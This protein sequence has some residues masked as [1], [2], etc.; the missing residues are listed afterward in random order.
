MNRNF[1]L[2]VLRAL[3][4]IFVLLSHSRFFLV[5]AIPEARYLQLGG[6]WGVELFFVLSGLLIGRIIVKEVI[7]EETFSLITFWK[8]RWY[9]TIPNYSLFL[10]LNILYLLTVS[11]SAAPI[12]KYFLFMQNFAWEHPLFFP[13]SWSL[14]VEEMFY[15]IFPILVVVL[16]R[17][18][19]KSERAF[20]MAGISILFL[21]TTFRFLHVYFT[22]PNWND[23]VRTIVIYRLDAL[24]YGILSALYLH[25]KKTIRRRAK[26]AFSGAGVTLL[27]MSALVFFSADR[28]QDF[29]SRT[30]LFSITS[31]GFALL[32]PAVMD[33][34]VPSSSF[35]EGF[36]RKI[37]LWS[38]SLYLSNFLVHNLI[39]ALWLQAAEKTV[40]NSLVAT[41]VFISTSV[42]VSAL[43]YHHYE[44]PM[45]K[46]RDKATFA[47]AKGWLLKRA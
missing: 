19:F 23:G 6:F 14:A 34:P 5:P 43:V 15:L 26:Y 7:E 17:L 8:R 38:Y 45:M 24:M 40:F 39:Q 37:A 4:I 31:L 32:M 46:L 3:A 27:T 29:F 33:S 42:L 21:S 25:R 20:L 18:K 47:Q 2:D 28:D 35:L 9:R 12:W 16:M 44:L 1:G 22:N 41:L 10:F 30:A 13:E 36:W 11:Y